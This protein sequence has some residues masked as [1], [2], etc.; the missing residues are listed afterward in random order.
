MVDFGRDAAIGDVK[1]LYELGEVELAW[2]LIPNEFIAVTGNGLLPVDPSKVG[3][4]LYLA[5]MSNT[6]GGSNDDSGVFLN[7]TAIAREMVGFIWAIA[8]LAQ[9]ALQRLRRH[10]RRVVAVVGPQRDP[11]LVGE[12]DDTLDVDAG[13]VAP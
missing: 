5:S 10:R 6:P 9:P 8:R 11:A 2:R 7:T 3:P 13:A 12:L 1:A 4:D